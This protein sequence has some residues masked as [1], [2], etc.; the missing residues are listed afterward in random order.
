MATAYGIHHDGRDVVV[1]P[2]SGWSEGV[3]LQVDGAQVAEAKRSSARFEVEANGIVVAIWMTNWGR[4]RSADLVLADGARLPMPARP[5][6]GTW[7]ARMHDWGERHP[8]T[9]AARHGLAGIFNALLL[10]VGI[11]FLLR[12]IPDI[13]APD[14]PSPNVPW[15]SIDLP[16]IPWPSIALPDIELPA[17]ADDAKRIVQAAAFIGFGIFLARR[18]YLRQRAIRERDASDTSPTPTDDDQA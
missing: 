15:P 13:D 14:V 5:T 1:V 7:A 8:R 16:R 9:W 2:F 6:P 17:W 18:E 10:F 12:L 3:T 11:G 4:I